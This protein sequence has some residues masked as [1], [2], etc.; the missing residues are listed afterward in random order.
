MTHVLI[1]LQSAFLKS[2]NPAVKAYFSQAL[3]S[4]FFDAAGDTEQQFRN[5]GWTSRTLE[6]V[7]LYEAYPNAWKSPELD[8]G[9][10]AFNVSRQGVESLQATFDQARQY[11]LRH[12]RDIHDVFELRRREMPG[13]KPKQGI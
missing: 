3:A 4:Y 2:T 1:Q 7:L 6:A 10:A 12:K 13:A 9:L 5:Q 11:F 8:T